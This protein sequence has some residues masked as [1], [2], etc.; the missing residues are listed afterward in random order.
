MLPMQH[1]PQKKH[2]LFDNHD[3][4]GQYAN[5]DRGIYGDFLKLR[6]FAGPLAARGKRLCSAAEGLAEATALG[7][8]HQ[9]GCDQYDRAQDKYDS[10]NYIQSRHLYTPPWNLSLRHCCQFSRKRYYIM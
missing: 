3:S 8:L 6:F 10:K 5:H 7:L 2:L 4:D 9:Y 1:T